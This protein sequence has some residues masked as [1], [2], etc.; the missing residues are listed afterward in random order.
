M[1]E[2]IFVAASHKD[3]RYVRRLVEELERRGLPVWTAEKLN[4]YGVEWVQTVEENI[5][6]SSAVIIIMSQDSHNSSWVQKE[7]SMARQLSKPIFPILLD[8]DPWL[9]L[10]SL[11]YVDG[12][13][14]DLPPAKFFERLA[15]V[16]LGK[17]IS[18][19][20]PMVE[21]V[22]PP[23]PFHGNTGFIFSSYKRE[24]MKVVAKHLNNIVGWGYPIWYDAGIPGGA[25]WLDMI[26]TRISQCSLFIVF[27]SP[28]AVNSKWVRSEVFLA[29]MKE[30]PI[31]AVKLEE[32]ELKQGLGLA[33]VS[34]QFLEGWSDKIEDNLKAAIRYHM[35]E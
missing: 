24:E 10:E 26:E 3:S 34:T 15:S 9:V 2:N 27:L 11:Q 25:D 14:H 31:I 28:A 4:S 21:T 17:A 6:S 18:T 23:K 35:H 33:L 29:M 7:I 32:V 30:K 8:G 5:K 22:L 20:K 12:R 13:N 16:V 19:D 1:K